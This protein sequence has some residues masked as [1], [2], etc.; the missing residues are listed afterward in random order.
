MTVT[1]F[2]ELTG[3]KIKSI[4][5]SVD[6]SGWVLDMKETFTEIL[7]VLRGSDSTIVIDDILILTAS[8]GEYFE[9]S[10]PTQW[11]LLNS[12][13]STSQIVLLFDEVL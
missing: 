8:E 3:K 4:S 13:G 11:S 1:D 7:K 6:V 10:S 2:D 5:I 9:F 12:S